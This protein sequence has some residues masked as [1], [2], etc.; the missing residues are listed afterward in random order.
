METSWSW[1]QSWKRSR[2]MIK[3]TVLA[4][5]K[6]KEPYINAAIDEYRKRL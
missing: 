1:K 4:I 2:E 6:I 3:I 5:G